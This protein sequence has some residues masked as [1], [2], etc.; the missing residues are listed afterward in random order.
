MDVIEVVVL[1]GVQLVA[2]ICTVAILK[3]D[4]K[5]IKEWCGK[6]ETNDSERFQQLT[7][8]DQRQEDVNRK[9]R[10]DLQDELGAVSNRV[11]SLEG[12]A[13]WVR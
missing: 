7:E 11:A 8:E 4:V 12:R 13:G 5:W 1:V 3:T 10:H 6:H 2:A 9:E